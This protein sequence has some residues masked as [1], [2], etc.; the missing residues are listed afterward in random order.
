ML[1]GIIGGSKCNKK[2]KKLAEE[3]GSEIA[4][5]R[6]TLVCGGMGGVMEAVC[7]GAKK[8]GGLT[9][10]ILPGKS[11]EDANKYIDIPII[12]AMS[13]A[14]NAIIVRTAD[15]VIAISGS[16]GT[17]SEIGL[18]KSIDKKVIG[19]N[20]WDIPGIKKID[21]IKQMIEEIEKAGDRE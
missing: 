8:S 17:L 3:V 18:A 4:K 16:Y 15:I 19:L 21:S 13:H 1:I 11:K 5:R 2:T 20:T 9:I 7:R 10:G 12:T 14:R 6:H